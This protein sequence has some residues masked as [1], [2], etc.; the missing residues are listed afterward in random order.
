MHRFHPSLSVDELHF[1]YKYKYELFVKYQ[2]NIGNWIVLLLMFIPTPHSL[3]L[4]ALVIILTSHPTLALAQA[5]PRSS[6]SSNSTI[7][8]SNA[9][10][11]L[12]S[13]LEKV[14]SLSNVLGASMVDG[15]QVSAINVGDTD[16]TVT[17]K[18]QQIINNSTT[19]AA[20]IS[21]TNNVGNVSLPVTVIAVK[22][23]ITNV[24]EIMSAIEA[25]R[26]SVTAS[27]STT[28]PT[29]TVSGQ[30]VFNDGSQR[31]GSQFLSLLKNI[32]IGAASIVGANWTTPQTVSMGF[33][34]LGNRIA[35]S[36]ASDFVVVVVV[37]FQ[38]ESSTTTLELG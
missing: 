21:A 13:K 23:P 28:N 9:T 1:V 25:S 27:G 6:N 16:L 26:S 5:P 2:I 34:G 8:N 19:G 3:A 24:T 31:N 15:I 33:L 38:G 7:S 18:R 37:P 30:T 10:S 29:D 32:Q 22:L 17:L 14:S 11:L 12:N 35:P 36:A 4:F 20:T